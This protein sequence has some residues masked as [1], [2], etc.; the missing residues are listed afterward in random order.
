MGSTDV[1][2][3]SNTQN[4]AKTDI[5]ASFMLIQARN[6]EIASTSKQGSKRLVQSVGTA[7]TSTD[8]N[9]KKILKKVDGD[10]NDPGAGASLPI[11]DGMWLMLMFA[12]VYGV[13]SLKSKQLE[14][15]RQDV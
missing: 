6:A 14:V 10:P 12:A 9:G 7:S 15:K 11:G 5:D 2:Y 8:V 1:Q 4:L 3:I 13:V